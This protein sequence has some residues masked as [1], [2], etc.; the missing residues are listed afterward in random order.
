MRLAGMCPDTI[1]GI[2]QGHE[3]EHSAHPQGRELGHPPKRDSGAGESLRG[4][5]VM[6]G[7]LPN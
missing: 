7:R 2:L 1:Q 5:A 3:H 4:N 6:S